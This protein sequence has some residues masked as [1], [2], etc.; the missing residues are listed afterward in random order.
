MK[1]ETIFAL[2]SAPGRAGVAVIRVSGPDAGAAVRR[3]TGREP[4]PPRRA[5]LRRLVNGGGAVLDEGLVLWFPGPASFTGE[6]V[7]ELHLH[8]GPAV[9]A[10]TVDALGDCPGLR[11]AEPGEFTRRAFENGKLDLTAAEGLADL[12]GAET[13]AQR[14]QALRQMQGELGRLYDGW[15]ERL[16][17]ALA[18]AEAAID[19]PDE[20]LPAELQERVAERI[21]G[22]CEEI[23]RHL[24][25]NRR[26]ERLREGVSIALIGAPNAGKSSLLNRLARRDAAI[27]SATAGTTRDVIE[28][29]LDLGG[30]P[31]IVADTAGL[32]AARDEIEAEG[33][34]RA[35]D[36]AAAADLKIALFD[37]QRWPEL[38]AET[39]KLL[40]GDSIPVLNK[41]DLRPVAEGVR[42]GGRPALRLSALTGEG[43]AAFLETVTE[44]VAE[45]IGASGTLPLTRARHRRALEDCRDA[46]RRAGTAALPELAA[47]DLRLAAT[48]LGRITGR[49][50]V[51]E[52]LDRIF[53]EFCIGK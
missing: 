28:V 36:R 39:V 5:A 16:V 19:F 17:A 21:S 29:H 11:P 25:D 1:R 45:R 53:R 26:G 41:I 48:A 23:E 34:R 42:I 43:I 4:P 37:A 40:D 38:D 46:L 32:R 10:A 30:Y 33:V 52:V 27:V 12:V 9:V 51:E 15:R 6:D 18:E 8:G 24:A 22:V 20:D 14:R 7:A 35:L 44:A 13:E 3:V 47:E 2:A 49:V 31:V 50:D